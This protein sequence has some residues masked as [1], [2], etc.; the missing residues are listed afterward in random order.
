MGSPLSFLLSLHSCP[1]L[2]RVCVVVM[3][4]RRRSLEGG[5]PVPAGPWPLGEAAG[6]PT[7]LVADMRADVLGL[8]RC[9]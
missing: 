3:F 5:P 7:P 9:V 4:R 8:R 6:P 2:P 1:P